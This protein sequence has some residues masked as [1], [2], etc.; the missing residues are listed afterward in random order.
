MRPAVIVD[1]GPIVALL[2]ADET[3]HRWA[4]KQFESL[5]PPLLTCE[6]VLSEACFLLRRIGVDASLPVTL[7]RRSVLRVVDVLATA[8]DADAVTALMRRDA[9]VPMSLADACLVRML[10]QTEN[11]SI[12]TLDS[13]FQVYRQSRRRTIRMLFPET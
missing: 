13:D 4:R 8:D 6:S 1:T 11:G 12:M 9:N 2:D 5:A 3:H 7:L 10:E